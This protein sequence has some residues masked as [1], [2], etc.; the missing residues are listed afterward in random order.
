MSARRAGGKLRDESGC[1]LE[2]FVVR[3][4]P[5][6]DAMMFHHPRRNLF[7]CERPLDGLGTAG[8]FCDTVDP[9]EQ[10]NDGQRLLRVT[11]ASRFR[12]DDHVRSYGKVKA[13]AEAQTLNGSNSWDGKPLELIERIHISFKQRAQLSCAHIGPGNDVAAEA[14]ISSFGA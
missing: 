1:L 7:R 8:A 3:H 14:E 2:E 5:I 11:E 12:R 4:D 9:A 6:D 10:R 13:A